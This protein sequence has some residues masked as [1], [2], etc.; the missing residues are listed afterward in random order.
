MKVVA[1]E[2]PPE[3][4]VRSDL[5]LLSEYR[6]SRSQEA[7]SALVGRHGAGVFRTCLR[8]AGNRHD[9]EDAA[10]AVFLILARRPEAVSRT[11]SGWLYGTACRTARRLVQGRARGKE[12]L[13]TMAVPQTPKEEDLRG[14]LDRALERLPEHYREAVVLRYLEGRSEKEAAELAG[15]PRGTL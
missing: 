1:V 8:I 2:S 12:I 7:F 10:Q 3:A 4:A 14:E 13:R 11:L 9:A 15:C 5:D 6:A